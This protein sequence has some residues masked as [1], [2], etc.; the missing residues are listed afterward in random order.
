MRI[1]KL[2]PNGRLKTWAVMCE[3]IAVPA[4]TEEA[5]DKIIEALEAAKQAGLRKA[6]RKLR[7]AL[8]IEECRCSDH[9]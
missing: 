3:G 7:D 5:A 1:H 9:C 8:G 4:D 2:K 6:Q